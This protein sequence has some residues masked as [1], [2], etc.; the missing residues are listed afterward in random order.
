[1]ASMN[2]YQT[3]KEKRKYSNSKIWFSEGKMIT[4]SPLS[5]RT[6][7]PTNPPIS[8]QFFHDFPHCLNFKSHS[9]PSL[10]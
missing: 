6:P 2:I 3:K 7:R 9:T 4:P 1:M 8:E 10:F 5:N